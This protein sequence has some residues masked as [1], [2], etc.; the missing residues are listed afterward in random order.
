M[1]VE[2]LQIRTG[3][4]PLVHFTGEEVT[5]WCSW[6]CAPGCGAAVWASRAGVRSAVSRLR[7]RGGRRPRGPQERPQVETSPGLE[8]QIHL[9]PFG[10]YLTGLEALRRSHYFSKGI[11]FHARV[12]SQNSL[13][14]CTSPRS[15]FFFFFNFLTATPLSGRKTGPVL[16]CCTSFVLRVF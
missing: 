10:L 14:F 16:W 11:W 6:P 2:C 4:R 13:A 5:G 12:I 9:L 7:G 1:S 15:P 3:L 8:G